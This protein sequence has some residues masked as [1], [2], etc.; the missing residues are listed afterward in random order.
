[1]SFKMADVKS[2][3]NN[4]SQRT[5]GRGTKITRTTVVP[6]SV[7]GSKLVLDQ[8]DLR[9]AMQK[10]TPKKSATVSRYPSPPCT[11]PRKTHGAGNIRH[12]QMSHATHNR[13]SE[14]DSTDGGNQSRPSSAFTP[15][16]P[17]P[18]IGQ[19]EH[20]HDVT[21]GMRNLELNHQDRV[22]VNATY[23]N[24]VSSE[25]GRQKSD[26]NYPEV[27][28]KRS[29]S[30]SSVP[31]S[32]KRVSRREMRSQQFARRRNSQKSLSIPDEPSIG[33]ERF[34]IA[35]KLPEGGRLQ[36]F[37]RPLDS[38]LDIVSYAEKESGR[39]FSDCNVFTSDVPKR[40]VSDLSVSLRVAGF[41]DRTLLYLEEKD[42]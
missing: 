22:G 18:Q 30:L 42:E 8:K 23:D 19:P 6:G 14:M 9:K 40:I 37:F 31:S 13:R 3:K 29:S 35:L 41:K 10:G 27:R 24:V 11:P 26:R 34:L 16:S 21:A 2:A 15:Y 39:S 38:F 4:D 12:G 28:T 1:M 25:T 33:E 20:D 36:R 32:N 5:S 17:L 7:V